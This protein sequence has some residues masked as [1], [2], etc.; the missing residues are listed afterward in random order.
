MASIDVT[1]FKI[2]VPEETLID[3]RRRL[4]NTIY[5]I[6]VDNDDWAYGT[7]AAYLR[8]VID[9]WLNEYDWRE[10]ER[11]INA[12]SHYRACIDDVPVHFIR[13]PGR[14]P[15]PIPLILS[16]GWPWTFW[17]LHKVIKPLADPAAFGGNPEDAFEVIVPSLP[18]FG[19]SSPLRKTGINFWKTSDLWHKLMTDALGFDRFGAQGGDWGASVTMQLGHK[20][21]ENMIGLHLTMTCP[22]TL[23]NTDRPWDLTGSMPVPPEFDAEQRAAFFAWQKTIASHV[24][25]Q[26]LDPQTLSFGLHDSPAGLLAW[27]LQRRREWGCCNGDVESRFDKD[28]MITTAMIY[29]VTQS[30]VTS[31]RFY[32]EA[33]RHPWQPSHEGVHVQVPT[34][35]SKML[36][37]GTAG[38]GFSDLSMFSN[39]IFKKEHPEGGHFSPAEIPNEI[40]EDIRETFRPLRGV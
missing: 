21:P 18:G 34:G 19:F 5:P 17:D 15:A 29:W 39:M 23:F 2:E 38:P 3:L 8:S 33:A 12:F 36:G 14:G 32:A 10:Q 22:L 16:H 37:D 20:Y 1:K 31:A 24:A 28:F 40:V 35:L 6:D 30:F 7:N 26:V 27:F 11:R 25:V 4:E 13:E 9:Y